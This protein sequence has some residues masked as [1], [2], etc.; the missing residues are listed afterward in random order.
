MVTEKQRANLKPPINKRPT[1]EQREIRK[2]AGINSGKSRREKKA[3]REWVLT[4]MH[5]SMS[6]DMCDKYELPHGTTYAAA[7]ALKGMKGFLDGNPAMARLM[8]ELIGETK[9]EINITGS[10]PVVIKDDVNE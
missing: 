2:K 3:I 7:M 5:D 6:D 10:I 8:L 9:Q 4:F 1:S